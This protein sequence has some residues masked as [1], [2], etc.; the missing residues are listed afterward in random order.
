MGRLSE[1]V[2]AHLS[3]QIVDVNAAIRRG[4]QITSA[5]NEWY[6]RLL[7][8]VDEEGDRLHPPQRHPTKE[9][10]GL[11]RKRSLNDQIVRDFDEPIEGNGPYPP[12]LLIRD[13]A[14]RRG[15]WALADGSRYLVPPWA[16]FRP[17]ILRCN[18]TQHRGTREDIRRR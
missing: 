16:H 7:R 9:V 8:R 5:P 1:R 4:I 10:A 18:R 11:R 15:E 6:E 2:E 14:V 3:D 13:R 17:L 12:D